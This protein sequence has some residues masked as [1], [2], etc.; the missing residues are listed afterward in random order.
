MFG[1]RPLST[2][3]LLQKE[4][5]SFL[6]FL[7]LSEMTVSFFAPVKTG[8]QNKSMTSSKNTWNMVQKENSYFV[9]GE[10]VVL[11]RMARPNE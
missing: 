1:T 3:I 6:E 7:H 10:E 8:L 2:F 9:V 5:G 4:Q 11:R